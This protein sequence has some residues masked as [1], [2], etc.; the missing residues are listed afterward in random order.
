M[1]VRKVFPKFSDFME[2]IVV[3]KRQIMCR[4]KAKQRL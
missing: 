1:Y 4:D 2:K 3:L